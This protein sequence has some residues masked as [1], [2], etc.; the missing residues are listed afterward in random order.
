LTTDE[1]IQAL[2]E[3]LYET[4]RM[5][6]RVAN[7]AENLTRYDLSGLKN[8]IIHAKNILNKI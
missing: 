8:D 1:K 7:D 2:K 6:H 5:L 3:A 4:L